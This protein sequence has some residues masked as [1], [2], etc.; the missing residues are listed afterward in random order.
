MAVIYGPPSNTRH[1]F[2]AQRLGEAETPLA[3]RSTL[4]AL[5]KAAFPQMDQEGIDALVLEKMLALARDLRVVVHT[6]DDD[7]L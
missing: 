7:D 3:F 1:R 4:L 2:A 5:P 6:I